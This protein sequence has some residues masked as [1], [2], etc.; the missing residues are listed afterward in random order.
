MSKSPVCRWMPTFTY[1]IQN[2]C[3]CK[4]NHH[5]IYK[6]VIDFSSVELPQRVFLACCYLLK[7][8]VD[9]YVK[10]KRKGGRK[11]EGLLKCVTEVSNPQPT[12][13][14]QLRTAMKA[15]HLKTVNL[16]KTLRDFLCV[17]VLQMY[18]MCG[19]RQLFFFHCGPEMPKSLTPLLDDT[20]SHTIFLRVARGRYWTRVCPP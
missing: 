5:W 10:Q 20:L 7:S 13:H 11:N 17:I 8:I 15:A 19:P 9:I 16:L 6:N 1:L 14:I 4:K 3:Y 12:G 18:L 2:I